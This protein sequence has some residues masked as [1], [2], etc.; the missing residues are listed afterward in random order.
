MIERSS[1]RVEAFRLSLGAMPGLAVVAA[2]GLLLVALG[3]N[4][5]RDDETGLQL[6]FWVGLVLIYGPIAFR[7]LSSKASREE[8][9]ALVLTLGISLFVVKVLRSPIDYVRFDELGWWRATQDIVRTGHAF[10]DNPIVVSTP[11]F[12][13]LAT[14]TAA[15]SQ[16][17]GLSIFHS[18]LILI[19]T[20][21]VILILT[22]FLFLERVIGSA[23]AAGIGI[24]VYVCNPSFLYF[25]AQFAYESLALMLGAVLLL[26]TLRWADYTQPDRRD[27]A[28]GIVGTLLV[29]TC[30]L[31]ITHHMTSF[32]LLAFLLLWTGTMAAMDRGSAPGFGYARDS[33][34]GPGLPAAVL[35]IAVG[36]WFAFVAA[37][38]TIDELGGVFSRAFHSVFDLIVGDS[39]SK[40]LFSGSGQQE[41]AVGRLL[42]LGSVVPFLIIIPLGLWKMWRE[43]DRDPLRVA[44]TG[45]AML[46]PLTLGLRL[47][48]ASSETSQRASEF[49]FVGVAFLAAVLIVDWDR[50][51]K[52]LN[53][54]VVSLG[55]TGV[56]VLSFVGG[57]FIGELQ[58]ARQPGSYLVGAEDRSITPQGLA[59]A[60]FAAGH[61]P[62]ESR[63]LTD[64]TNATL[65]GA[66]G[67]VDPIFG[68][69]A[70]ISLPR[71]LFGDQFDEDD[72]KAIHGQSLSYL[73]VD[74]RL[75]RELPVIGYYVES[76]ESGAFTRKEPVDR[77]A[78]EKF[79]SVP[80]LNKIYSNG[81]ITIYNTSALLK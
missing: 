41:H 75:S 59:A 63:L 38:V 52:R 81:P 49:V 22:L 66:Y 16:L 58:A 17:T 5:A 73:V 6:L 39:E 23:R 15:L 9:I 40:Q 57:F 4:G 76:D 1:G 21:R 13:G 29:L 33:L 14:I 64:R 56:A 32:A 69:Y 43:E 2:I 3:N 47:T 27:L 48:L 53:T 19:G 45:V 7:L 61:L 80:S 42:A 60:S 10:G 28:A 71:I 50:S 36:L 67:E 54:T 74:T 31:T 55:L 35:A 72:R 20:A 68:R 24:A 18:G 62:D 37:G 34:K 77:A 51:R 46:Y 12:P 25:D 78:L 30:A 70:D 8:R 44:L 26:A 11:G 65:L 79:E